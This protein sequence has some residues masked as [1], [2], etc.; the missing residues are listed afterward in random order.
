[1]K[2]QNLALLTVD[3]RSDYI[4]TA[5][6]ESGLAEL[7]IEKDFWVVWLLEQLFALSSSLGPFTFKGG[8]SLSKG[9]KAIQRFS[10]DLDISIGRTTLGFPDDGYF[11]KAPSAKAAKQRVEQ[12]RNVVKQYTIES[13]LPALRDQLAGK[14][15]GPWSL[16]SIEPGSLRFQYPTSQIGMIG[17]I[18]PDVLIEFGH[19]DSW[20]AADVTISPYLVDA[21]ESITGSITAR[22]LDPQRTFWEKATILHEIAHRDEHL[23]FPLRYSRHYYD[24]TCLGRTEIGPLA[25]QNTALLEA[26]VRFKSVFFASNRARYDLAKPGSLR[27][28]PPAFRHKT[29]AD[30]YAQMSE[31]IFG[32]VP[33]YDE[34]MEDLAD[35]ETRFN[36]LP[37]P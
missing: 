19:A 15:Q 36:T 27:L 22:V 6:A 24:L 7:I 37:R 21:L 10:E 3:E 20:P 29:I 4:R 17:Y 8:T 28:V 12:I 25:I 32:A 35:L 23:I 14:V 30:D 11:Y 18:K 1:M 33:P 31:M 16:E 13:L 2:F 34:L 5:A 26:V 9:F